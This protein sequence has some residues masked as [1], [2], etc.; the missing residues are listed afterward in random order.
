LTLSKS[1]PS[2]HLWEVKES[3]VSKQSQLHG[4]S[5]SCLA[6]EIKLRSR[7]SSTSDFQIFSIDSSASL[8]SFFIDASSVSSSHSS[9]LS[10]DIPEECLKSSAESLRHTDHDEFRKELAYV[11]EVFGGSLT[12]KQV[13]L[14]DSC[15]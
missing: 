8:N 10:T 2:W 14:I 9:R 7:S 1:V 12:I 15:V 11:L 13:F 6:F 3:E 4:V 5:D